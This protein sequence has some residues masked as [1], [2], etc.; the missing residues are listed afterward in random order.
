MYQ[1]RSGDGQQA[2]EISNQLWIPKQLSSMACGSSMVPTVSPLNPRETHL[3]SRRSNHRPIAPSGAGELS[4]REV[5]R[6]PGHPA[7]TGYRG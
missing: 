6:R 3:R 4:T 1:R 5:D 2:V 7:D